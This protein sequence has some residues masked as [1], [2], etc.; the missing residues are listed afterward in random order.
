MNVMWV[1]EAGNSLQGE[2][3]RWG[4]EGF[5]VRTLEGQDEFC[6]FAGSHS[7]FDGRSS[8]DMA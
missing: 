5:W 8:H 7:Y 1:P 2:V 3:G 4:G 6:A